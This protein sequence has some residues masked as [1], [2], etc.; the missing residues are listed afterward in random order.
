MI[1]YTDAQG[2]D[3]WL[4]ARRGVIT[5]SKF[6]TAR[7]KSVKTGA[8]NKSALLYA[9]NVAR[10]R[11]GGAVAAIFQTAAMKTGTEQEPVARLQYELETG[12][13]VA[14]AGFICTDDRRFGVSVDGLIGDA[15]VWECKT[16]VSSDTLFT[17]LVGGDVSAYRDQ[18]VGA[19]WL[20]RR[21]WIDLSLW[22]PDLQLLRT[23][24][25]ERN[26]DEIER[27]EA[28][29]VA[30]EQQVSRYERD[31]R[32][33]MNPAPAAPAAIPKTPRAEPMAYDAIFA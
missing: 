7:E 22:C 28:D 20:L 3:E 19:L 24:R 33:A 10:E 12:A 31:L 15:G 9:M 23:I 13:M 17:A 6:A 26:D 2:S 32:A 14:E 1:T 18:C 5:A 25:I 16:M 29:M 4:A 11:A 30:F 8:P 21:E 27:L